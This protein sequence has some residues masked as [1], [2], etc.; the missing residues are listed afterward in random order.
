MGAIAAPCFITPHIAAA[1]AAAAAS[2]SPNLQLRSR[3]AGV[4]ETETC[5]WGRKACSLAHRGPAL[6]RKEAAAEVGSLAFASWNCWALPASPP[7]QFHTGLPKVGGTS[8]PAAFVRSAVCD[9]PRI[10]HLA[11]SLCRAGISPWPPYLSWQHCGSGGWLAGP[12]QAGSGAFGSGRG[13]RAGLDGW[14]S[15][16]LA[17]CSCHCRDAQPSAGVPICPLETRLV[18]CGLLFAG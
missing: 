8:P 11:P 18:L 12:S 7:G 17:C 1:A 6:G 10:C 4:G 3:D 15:T 13:R 5:G 2:S 16:D 14:W 9:W